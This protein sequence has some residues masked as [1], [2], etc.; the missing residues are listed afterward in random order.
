MRLLDKAQ[1]MLTL[2]SLGMDGEPRGRFERAFNQAYGAVLATGPTGSGKSTTLYAAL[3][4]INSPDKNIITIE[5]PA[6]YQLP[7]VNQLQVN[8]KA[9][10]TFA[11][12][13]R[14]GRLRSVST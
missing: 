7:G 14:S 3:N 1:A 2:D 6:E 11:R 10:L 9:G 5:D 13:L 12:G 4:A 8:L